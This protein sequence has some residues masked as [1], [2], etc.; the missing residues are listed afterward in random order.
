MS[1]INPEC[2]ALDLHREAIVIDC[3]S[4]ILIPVMEGKLRLGERFAVPDPAGWT[5]PPGMEAGL[6]FGF[7]PH[8]TYFGPMG[9]YDLPRW[10]EGG[11]TAPVCAIYI[12]DRDL[13][14]SLQKGLEMAWCL[15]HEIEANDRLELVTTA[16]DIRRCKREGKVGAILSFE[17]FEALGVELRFLDLYYKLGL[18]MASLTHC[19]RNVFADGCA[20]DDTKGG[21]LTGLGRQAIRRMNELGIVVDLVHINEVG[22]WDV[23]EL[24]RAP[25]VCSHSTGTM[26]AHPD[27]A[28]GRPA[29]LPGRPGLV[30]PRDR[31]RLEAIAANGGVLGIIFF[32]RET[33][34]DVVADIETALEA[35]GPDHV[36]LGSDFYGIDLSPRG[37]EDIGKVPTLTRR[38]VERGHSD[39]VIL[40][41]LGGNFLRVFEQVW[42]NDA[43]A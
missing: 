30:L 8:A 11:V 31:E 34:D 4:D 24:S 36:G 1:G 15:H 43:A 3:H 37:L 9:Q 14:R 18:R 5:P 10:I 7:S 33:V 26:F 32:D 17:G 25:V 13:D 23:L 28:P 41:I 21:G 27:P 20:F 2:H 38:L 35:M 39:E 29:E 12:E 19:R 40:K 16:A 6:G 42:H 22:F